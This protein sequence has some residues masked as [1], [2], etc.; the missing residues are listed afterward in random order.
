MRVLILICFLLIVNLSFGQIKIDKAGNGWD[1]KIDSA[2]TLIRKT[3]I[4]KL[5][6]P[7]IGNIPL[8][9]KDQ[10][11]VIS[12]GSKTAISESFRSL[13]TNVDFMLGGKNHGRGNFIFITS[14]VAKE[15]KSFTAVNFSLSIAL[16]GKK[17]LLLGMDLRAPKLEQYLGKEKSKGVTNFLVN[18]SSSI[19]DYICCRHGEI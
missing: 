4:E 9:Q 7:Y 13:R 16:S 14:T 18:S 10:Q 19:S 2:L 6:L 15:G 17:V 3:D 5:K 12:K 1:L 11:I 8:G